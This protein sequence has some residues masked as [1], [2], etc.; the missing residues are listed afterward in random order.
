MATGAVPSLGA[1][2]RREI[3]DGLVTG[4]AKS[5]LV[6]SLGIALFGCGAKEDPSAGQPI[7]KASLAG[8]GPKS[9]GVTKASGQQMDQDQKDAIAFEQGK[10]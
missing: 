1:A 9:A 6:V 10:K 7:D 3:R 2:R 5:V 8:T 4:K